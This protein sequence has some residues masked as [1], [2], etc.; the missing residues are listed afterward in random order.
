MWTAVLV[1]ALAAVPA[2]PIPSE[3]VVLAVQGAGLDFELRLER[4]PADFRPPG[5]PRDRASDYADYSRAGRL[6]LRK[7]ALLGPSPSGDFVVPAGDYE[8]GLVPSAS[9]LPALK[10]TG[11][12]GLSLRLA[13]VAAPARTPR[14]A[15]LD[16]EGIPGDAS[17][18]LLVHLPTVSAMAVLRPAPPPS[19]PA[20]KPAP[21]ELAEIPSPTPAAATE[22]P[23][24]PAGRPS[25]S[26]RIR[27]RVEAREQRDKETPR[28]P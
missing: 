1:L 24:E 15:A 6:L 19:A 8:T 13:L 11:A 16:A 22:R 21:A 3:P 28:R 20:P 23:S 25:R 14:P 2:P 5:A 10:L 12:N 9:G 4:V 7:A 17:W 27:Q 18:T 26:E